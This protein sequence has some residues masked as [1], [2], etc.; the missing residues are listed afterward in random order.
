[1]PTLKDQRLLFLAGA[2]VAGSWK[3]IV[4]GNRKPQYPI[5]VKDSS[6]MIYLEGTKIWI[7]RQAAIILITTRQ[8]AQ[9][10]ACGNWTT[11]NAP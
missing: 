9:V 4:S 7:N 8:D 3:A 6:A 10:S 1:M 5:I 2:L 11:H